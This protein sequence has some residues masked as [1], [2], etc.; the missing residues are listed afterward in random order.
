[1]CRGQPTSATSTPEWYDDGVVSIFSSGYKA[2]DE[3]MSCDMEFNNLRAANA[4]RIG[5]MEQY[6]KENNTTRDSRND[7]EV[8]DLQDYGRRPKSERGENRKHNLPIPLGKAT[9]VK[10]TY[11]IAGAPFDLTV[12]Q[13]DDSALERHRSQIMEQVAWSV[14]K[15]SKGE[16]TVA[17]GAWDGSEIGTTVF[18]LYFDIAKNAVCFRR[19]DPVGFMEVQG[20]DDPHSFERTYRWWKA[21]VATLRAQ[22][23]D[24]LVGLNPVAI[25]SIRSSSKDGDVEMCEVRQMNTKTGYRR[26]VGGG[27]ES[28]TVELFAQTHDY[29]F[30]PNVVIPNIG[31]YDDVWGFADYEFVRALAA[32]IPQLLA[33]EADV[34]RAVANGAMIEHGTGQQSE[35]IK[36]A[37]AEGGIVP[38]KRDGSIEPIQAPDMPAFHDSHSNQAD[39]LFK[40]VGFAPAAAW[41]EPGSGS[42]SDRGL[43]LQPLLEYTGMKQMNWSAGMSR[44][45]GY[46]W[47]Q[48]L[49]WRGSR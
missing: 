25:D 34:L 14:F 36:K 9:T 13:R 45:F 43:Q 37:I 7:L 42:G 44:L 29:G 28:S 3:L 19:I 39:A 4:D 22:Y 41:G 16:T 49:L 38:S 21:P 33:R 20:V 47:H 12:E 46:A 17:S 31:P 32:Y 18:D 6:R 23:A 48:V 30:V 8:F 1:M 15:H 40:M 10:H 26:W 27:D 5:R 2:T 11:R 35:T 24:R